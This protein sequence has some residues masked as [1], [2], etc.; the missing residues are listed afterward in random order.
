MNGKGEAQ[1]LF[2]GFL[3]VVG[4]SL[5]LPATREAV[6]WLGPTVV[7]FGRA[8]VAALIAGVVLFVRR[9]RFPRKEWG[10]LAVVAIGVVLG[11]PWLSA[12]A[13]DRVPASHGAVILAL[14]PLATAGAAAWRAGERPSTR[15]WLAGA[16]GSAVLTAY[17]FEEGAGQVTPSDGALLAAVMLAAFGYAEG[18]R[19]A[20]TLGGWRVISWALVLSLPVALAPAVGAAARL[21]WPSVPPAVWGSFLYVALGSQLLAFFAWYHG[22]ASG[23]VARVSQVQYLQVF[24]TLGWSALWLREHLTWMSGLASILIVVA[25]AVGRG[26]PIGQAVAPQAGPS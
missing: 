4:F 1:G 18:G 19:L 11:F 8:V 15:F 9:E 22:L 6:P 16:L 26:A 7:G 23:G 21:P 17:A 2:W 12:W 3:G 25:V 5:T 24:L 20:R 10:A 14:L 13:M